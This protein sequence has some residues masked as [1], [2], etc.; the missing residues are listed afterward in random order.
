MLIIAIYVVPTYY[1]IGTYFILY[2]LSSYNLSCSSPR[3]F[4]NK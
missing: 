4:Q 2:G 1:I 3:S